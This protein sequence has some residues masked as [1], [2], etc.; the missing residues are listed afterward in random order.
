MSTWA[1]TSQLALSLLGVRRKLE[2]S[3]C[4]SRHSLRRR[5]VTNVKQ[6]QKTRTSTRFSVFVCV[7]DTF[8]KDY[9]E[10]AEN[11]EPFIVNSQRQRNGIKQS[12]TAPWRMCGHMDQNPG[13]DYV[14]ALPFTFAKRARF[15]SH[16]SINICLVLD[17]ETGDA[18]SCDS[19]QMCSGRV[20]S[21]RRQSIR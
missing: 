3:I 5:S 10:H 12:P 8:L 2:S 17:R 4:Y 11:I 19:G 20:G 6:V 18:Y 15:S 16:R 21:K 9:W 14:I 13:S 7:S 1:K